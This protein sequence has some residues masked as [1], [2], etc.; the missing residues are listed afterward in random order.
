M[1]IVYGLSAL[2][3]AIGRRFVRVPAYGMPNLIAG[4]Q[5]V[6]E[7]IQENFTPENVARETVSLLIDSGR[8]DRVRADLADVRRALG[9]PGASMRVARAVLEI[10]ARPERSRRPAEAR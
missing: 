8:A 3:H 10:A 1:V 5:I 4:R 2:T 7:L 6:P 9:E